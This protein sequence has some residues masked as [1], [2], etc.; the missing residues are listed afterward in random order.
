MQKIVTS[1]V[2]LLFD[3]RVNRALRRGWKIKEMRD[4]SGLLGRFILV[5]VLE[6]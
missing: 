4:Y 2:P 1:L 6:K 3:F 5:V